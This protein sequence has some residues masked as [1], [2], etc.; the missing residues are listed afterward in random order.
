MAGDAG[1]DALACVVSGEL[2][3]ASDESCASECASLRLE[4]DALASPELEEAFG[5]SDRLEF[6]GFP[7]WLRGFRCRV[8]PS[9]LP[10]GRLRRPPP[11]RGSRG[12]LE[13]DVFFLFVFFFAGIQ[14]ELGLLLSSCFVLISA[15]LL[16]ACSSVQSGF[17]ISQLR[18]SDPPILCRYPVYFLN[19]ACTDILCAPAP[20][21]CATPPLQ[22][23]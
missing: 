10:S 14:S 13:R 9:G 3:S 21:A 11:S 22:K 4:E 2:R 8:L 19:L 5:L 6:A 12:P 23:Q 1:G 20:C 17:L 16:N 15:T 18:N 7:V